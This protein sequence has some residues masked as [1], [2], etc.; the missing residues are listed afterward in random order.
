MDPL[1]VGDHSISFEPPDVL[2]TSLRG[3]V[4]PE[5][6]RAIAAF[7]RRASPGPRPTFILA[8]VADLREVAREARR[9]AV[10][11]PA[12]ARYRG[13]AVYNAS[14]QV[15]VLMKFVLLAFNLIAGV[16][17]NPMEFFATETEARRWIDERR[18][19]LA[20]EEPAG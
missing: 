18:R 17:D 11:E 3:D 15:R 19:T 16:T 8:D 12:Y 14:F 10:K 2:K 6:V 7:I 20:R 5:D 4:T 1:R 13:I 9:E